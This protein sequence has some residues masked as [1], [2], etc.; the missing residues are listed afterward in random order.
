MGHTLS[1]SEQREKLSELISNFSTAMLVT[2]T[3]DGGMRARPLSIADKRDD[4][5]LYF[6]TAIDSPKVHEL[7]ADQHVNVVMQDA[8]KFVSVSGLARVVRDRALIDELWS[9]AWKV[10]FPKG[11]DDPKLCLLVIDPTEASYWDMS[12]TEGIR[13]VFEMAK[14][15]VTGSRPPSDDDERHTGRVKL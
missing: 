3:A 5:E 4:G 10:W 13:Y 15:Y 1:D 6:S 2:R 11:K 7:E 9:E 14:A 12:G 8:R